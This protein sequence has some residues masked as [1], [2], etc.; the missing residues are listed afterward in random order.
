MER[1]RKPIPTPPEH[2]DHLWELTN[3]WRE[4]LSMPEE[5][6]VSVEEW[7]SMIM[8]GLHAEGFSAPRAE[9][10]NVLAQ[11]DATTWPY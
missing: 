6:R 7:R 4:Y 1:S 10:V 9:V 5:E 8:D 3:Q 11:L 2:I